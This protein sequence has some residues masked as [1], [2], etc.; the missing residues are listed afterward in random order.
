MKQHLCSL[1]YFTTFIGL[2]ISVLACAG[3]PETLAPEAQTNIKTEISE[4]MIGAEAPV[5]DDTASPL[6]HDTS[7]SIQVADPDTESGFT[8]TDLSAPELPEDSP[9]LWTF[10]PEPDAVI[11][12]PRESQP[13]TPVPATPVPA[14][15]VPAT[16]VPATPVPEREPAGQPPRSP[17]PPRPPA[18][19]AAVPPA[20]PTRTTEQA[21]PSPGVGAPTIPAVKQPPIAVTPQAQSPELIPPVSG[22]I[23]ESEPV[24]PG[25]FTHSL[26]SEPR[27]DRRV[28]VELTQILEVPYPGSGWV[29]LG[30]ST[31]QSGI[32]YE[33]RRLEGRDTLFTFRPLKEG[34]YLLSFSRFDVLKDEFISDVLQVTVTASTG[35]QLSRIRATPFT[36]APPSPALTTPSA[37]ASAVG[38]S[39]GL[40]GPNSTFPPTS[41]D[42]R[43]II[44]TSPVTSVNEPSVVA[45]PV[46]SEPV[47]IVQTDPAVLL[48]EIRTTLGKGQTDTALDLLNRFFA[49]SVNQIDEGLF[50][51]GQA[52]E[53]VGPRRDIRK[54][55]DS[56]QK[57]VSAY[58]DSRFWDEA[59]AR[60][61]FIR[62]FYF[63]IR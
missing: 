31:S 12:L 56:Y 21:T 18:T 47:G 59:D 17:V 45:T 41:V 34:V 15:P 57:L 63:S 16:P 44:G 32:R 33:S 53:S 4:D 24:L 62:H 5:Q 9:L 38:P 26:I 42:Q 30:D 25:P 10:Y 36:L 46:L 22:G 20:Q 51:Q 61:R 13:A 55:L 23:W 60:I 37:G 54:A 8:N 48:A 58:P 7:P 28:Q 2:L 14:T 40:A 50:L 19:T 49:V 35:R 6:F 11:I 3:D 52:L 39:T 1:F 27:P 43:N 29:F